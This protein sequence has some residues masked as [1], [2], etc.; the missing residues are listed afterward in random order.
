[1]KY[2][3]VTPYAYK[4]YFEEFEATLKI[5]RENC[6]F[7]DDTEPVGGIGIMK[8]HNMGID[9]MKQRGANYLIVMSAGIRFGEAGGLDF[10]EV[11]EQHPELLV[12]NGAGWTDV[13]G[14]RER[15]ALGY[16]LTAFKREV[17]DAI[18]RWDE[19]FSPYGFDDIDLMLRMKKYFG[20]EYK[21]DS[22]PVDMEHVS[23]SHSI[24]IAGVQA[25]STPRIL[26]FTEKWGRHPGAWQWD[27]WAYP[28]NNPDNNLAYWPPAANGGKWND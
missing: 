17:F 10:L 7:I 26:Y 9:F 8:A 28:F 27:G 15:V 16:H 24:Q 25:P 13:S 12:I 2:V 14:T 21:I 22:F 18:G 6:L 4:P 11:I 5:P 23:T 20:T 1:M 3:V 19:N